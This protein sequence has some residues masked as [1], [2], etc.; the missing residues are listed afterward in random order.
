MI[1]VYT[2]SRSS[3][4]AMIA[5]A[6]RGRKRCRRRMFSRH[7]SSIRAFHASRTTPTATLLIVLDQRLHDLDEGFVFLASNLHVVHG[8][9]R[10]PSDLVPHGARRAAIEPSPTSPR[11]ARRPS[12]APPRPSRR[13][14]SRPPQAARPRNRRS[15]PSSGSP[16]RSRPG[17]VE[18]ATDRAAV[19]RASRLGLWRTCERNRPVQ[20][21]EP[22]RL[23]D[24]DRTH[25]H[26]RPRR[27]P[28]RSRLRGRMGRDGP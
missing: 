16:P 4:S 6:L 22:V 15:R 12:S 23:D 2:R 26:Q 5:A 7:R 24:R 11:R 14:P 21:A 17:H 19:I 10:P 25:P 20:E 9:E 1:A 18:N 3:C 8:Q 28:R 27:S 13:P